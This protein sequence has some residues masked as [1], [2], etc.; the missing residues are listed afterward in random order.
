MARWLGE[1]SRT[2]N[3]TFSRTGNRFNMLPK[4]FGI[5]AFVQLNKR[6]LNAQKGCWV[7]AGHKTCMLSILDKISASGWMWSHARGKKLFSPSEINIFPFTYDL[8]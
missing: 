8:H 6:K 3:M 7:C 4:T 5:T 1:E 2:S